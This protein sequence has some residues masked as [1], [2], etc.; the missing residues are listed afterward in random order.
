MCVEG[1]CQLN[2]LIGYK[3]EVRGRGLLR[4]VG[5]YVLKG[6]TIGGVTRTSRIPHGRSVHVVREGSFKDDPLVQ[7][8]DGTVGDPK[9][10]VHRS[11]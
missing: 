7:S 4:V 1:S 11:T 8:F 5:E 3:G 2:R 9:Q 10:G 6:H